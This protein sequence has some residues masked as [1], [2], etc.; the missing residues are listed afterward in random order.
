MKST[1]IA[2]RLRSTLQLIALLALVAASAQASKWRTCN[3]KPIVWN[4]GKTTMYLST[5]DL[6]IGGDYDVAFQDAMFRWN[7]VGG[8]GFTYYVGR[9]T[10]GS[11]WMGNGDNEVYIGIPDDPDALA[12]TAYNKHC[13]SVLGFWF[14]G[15]DEEDIVFNAYVD[16]N[17][18]EFDYSEDLKKG[19]SESHHF[20]TVA[21]HELGHALGLLDTEGSTMAT[22]NAYYPNGGPQGYLK[23][24]A[25]LADDRGGART[26]YPDGTTETDVA[27]SVF[28]S[29]GGGTSGLVSYP[30]SAHPGDKVTLEYTISN[31][32]TST[33]YVDASYYLS[34][35][36]YISVYDTWLGTTSFIPGLDKGTYT[37]KV[38]LTIPASTTPG[39]Y[40]LGVLLD[41]TDSVS[42]L[43]EDNNR[44][45]MPFQTAIE[46]ATCA[47]K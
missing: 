23:Q 6:P 46:P 47:H 39:C 29:T 27:A 34:T 19:L 36:D 41:P 15:L 28:K 16:W 26:L 20:E 9:D 30:T 1:H 22:M 33:A 25:P 40:Y 12:A 24:S 5:H 18:G 31:K 17:T 8:S 11:A 38:N 44:Q 43:N 2:F 10:D 21:V 37:E 4:K 35:N 42:E 45:P 13:Y 7:I 3:G 32:G 14:S